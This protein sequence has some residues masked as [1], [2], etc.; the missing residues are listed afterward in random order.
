[1]ITFSL[2]EPATEDFFMTSS[3]NFN[4]KKPFN[5]NVV[6]KYSFTVTARVRG[7]VHTERLAACGFYQKVA[8]LSL[9]S[10]CCRLQ[11]NGGLNDTA[12][13]VIRIEDFD[14]LNPYF[15]HSLYQASIPENDVS[16]IHL[17]LQHFSVT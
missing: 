15:S 13:V 6:P 4:L 3:G 1:M 11:D 14:N 17:T 7:H 12:T 9:L 16:L 8:G 5:Y 2:K 10:D